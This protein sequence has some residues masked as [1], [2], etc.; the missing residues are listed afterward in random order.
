[1]PLAREIT[2]GIK[3]KMVVRYPFKGGLKTRRGRGL[4]RKGK[5][6]TSLYVSYVRL[7]HRL[8]KEKKK[9]VIKELKENT[10]PVLRR[11]VKRMQVQ[12]EC[13]AFVQLV[14]RDRRRGRCNESSILQLGMLPIALGGG[15]GGCTEG[16]LFIIEPG[17]S[18]YGVFSGRGAKGTL[19][20]LKG[21]KN[22]ERPLEKKENDFTLVTKENLCPS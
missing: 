20:I 15:R 17:R 11:G 2:G 12:C 3:R 18:S 8:L 14:R 21:R 16:K 13:L 19:F 4:S 1:V 5:T 6:G 7:G 22:V 9:G 10:F